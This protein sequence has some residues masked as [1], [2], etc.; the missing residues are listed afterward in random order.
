VLSAYSA[1]RFMLSRLRV[2]R[3][4]TI[5]NSGR[6]SFLASSRLQRRQQLSFQTTRNNRRYLHLFGLTAVVIVSLGWLVYDDEHR[7]TAKRTLIAIQRSSRVSN[8]VILSMIDYKRTFAR[9]FKFEDD[10][11]QAYSECHLRS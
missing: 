11:R 5:E 3:P 10:R 6:N 7:K 4:C 1:F 8:A 9:T 2:W